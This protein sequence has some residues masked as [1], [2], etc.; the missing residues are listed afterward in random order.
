MDCT[1]RIVLRNLAPQSN[2]VG[3]RDSRNFTYFEAMGVGRHMTNHVSETWQAMCH[4]AWQ[5]PIHVGHMES[6]VSSYMA[7]LNPINK[8][9]QFSLWESSISVR[10]RSNKEKEEEGK[11]EREEWK[12]EREERKGEREEKKRKGKK[13]REEESGGREERERGK[14]RSVAQ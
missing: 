8:G 4:I 10:G 7:L 2:L 14:G 9:F 3:L 11:R 5:G 6:H 1:V 12:R 13:K